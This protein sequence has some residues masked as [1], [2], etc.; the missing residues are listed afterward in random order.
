MKVES[1]VN[2]YTFVWKLS[3]EKKGLKQAKH[4]AR[5]VDF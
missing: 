1:S 2:K 3:I 4:A 5:I